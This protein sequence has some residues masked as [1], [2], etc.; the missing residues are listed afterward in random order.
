MIKKI[1]LALSLLVF[2]SIVLS[3]QQIKNGFYTNGNVCLCLS[4]DTITYHND[5]YWF[6]GTYTIVNNKLY[7][8]NNVLLG[9]NAYIVKENCAKDSI[10]V[11]LIT[12]YKG[13]SIHD[14]IIYQ[15]ESDYYN[16][17]I[18]NKPIIA[19]NKDGMNIA[20]GDFSQEELSVG[21]YIND[22]GRGF[23]DYF[24]IT[25]EY[26]TRYIIKQKYY[27]F[28]PIPEY[29]SMNNY[30]I[31]KYRNNEILFKYSPSYEKRYTTLKYISPNCDSCFN[32]LK[33]KFPLL[34]E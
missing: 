29:G 14:T 21:F 4:N 17:T 20:K 2:V 15:D 3:A 30:S 31:I 25:L 28:R 11:S 22:S 5:F 26:G 32:E 6:K 8:G 18:N 9:K 16:M 7:W 34:F 23:T 12:K 33:N 24:P 13:Y 27:K 19:S 1:F 10:E